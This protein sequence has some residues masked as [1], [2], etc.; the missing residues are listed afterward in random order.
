M[1]MHV[2]SS[3]KYFIIIMQETGF[4]TNLLEQMFYILLYL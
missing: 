1:Y 3:K 4:N 2:S